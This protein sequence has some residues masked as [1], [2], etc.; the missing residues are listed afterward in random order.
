MSSA[1]SAVFQSQKLMTR[2]CHLSDHDS[3]VDGA[4]GLGPGFVK[5]QSLKSSLRGLELVVSQ[6]A[7]CVVTMVS[8]RNS[9]SRFGP[10][11]WKPSIMS[12][13]RSQPRQRHKSFQGKVLLPRTR[14]DCV[15]PPKCGGITG[16]YV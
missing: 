3:F 9:L 16:E 4:R 14:E 15:N 12:S 10:H 6:P 1:W 11:R 8:H 13:D 5:R 2:P 7:C